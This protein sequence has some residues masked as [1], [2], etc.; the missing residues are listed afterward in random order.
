MSG[1]GKLERQFDICVLPKYDQFLLSGNDVLIGGLG[2]FVFFFLFPL[3]LLF[4]LCDV[5]KS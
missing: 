3:K 2:L 1:I 5:Q 4:N